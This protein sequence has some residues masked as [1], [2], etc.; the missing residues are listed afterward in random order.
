LGGVLAAVLGTTLHAQILPVGEVAL[1]LGAAA[2][3]VLAGSIILWCGL[4]ARSLLITALSGG[5]AYLVVALLSL[6]SETLILTGTEGPGPEPAAVLAGNIWMFGLALVTVAAVGLCAAA[7]RGPR[8]A[9]RRT[10][11]RSDAS[12]PSGP[13]DGR[14]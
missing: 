3:L 5:T 1:P 12:R 2:A 14:A 9:V 13:G 10:D 6:S 4:W 11:L 7:L 8:P